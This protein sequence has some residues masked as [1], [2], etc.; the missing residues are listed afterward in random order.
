M[1]NKVELRSAVIA[2]VVA[3]CVAAPLSD[4]ANTQLGHAVKTLR[5]KRGARGSAGPT[6]PTGPRGVGLDSA[7]WEASAQGPVAAGGFASFVAE[8]TSDHVAVDGG[9]LVSSA[10]V[11]V[12]GFERLSTYIGDKRNGYR[13]SVRNTGSDSASAQ[14]RVYC[15]Q[16]SG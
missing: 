11:R 7:A 2:A 9:F 5:G 8:C 12:V 15:A 14:V 4:A 13:L 1:K 6:G 16:R 3:A 10:E